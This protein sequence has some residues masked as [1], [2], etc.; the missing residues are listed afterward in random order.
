MDTA[1]ATQVTVFSHKSIEYYTPP[2]YIEAARHVLGYIDLDPA[3]CHYA[4]TWIQ[5]GT[6]FTKNMDGL[7]RSWFGRVFLN[8]P[9][10]KTRG[11]SNQEI[12]SRKLEDE[13][14]AGHVEAAV[15]LVKAA[16][17][18]NWFEHLF[19]RYPVCFTRDRIRFLT[20]D[21]EMPPAKQANAFF[22]LYK[23]HDIRLYIRFVET[24][25]AFGRVIP[26]LSRGAFVGAI[27]QG[28]AY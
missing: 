17:G 24:F 8:P 7:S 6:Y 22:L 18:Y 4:Q 16:L 2:A 23:E 14:D 9:Y 21:G 26:P 28:L 19:A 1:Q 20:V 27:P 3:S 13:I 12:W 10:S 5:A 11:R 25:R 15:L